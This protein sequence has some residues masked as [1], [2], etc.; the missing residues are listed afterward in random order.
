[1]KMTFLKKV[2]GNKCFRLKKLLEWKWGQKTLLEPSK[3]QNKW[4]SP[5]YAF[6]A[7]NEAKGPPFVFFQKFSK[8]KFL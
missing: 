4:F 5:N 8:I 6:L 1:M 2:E 3:G 7:E